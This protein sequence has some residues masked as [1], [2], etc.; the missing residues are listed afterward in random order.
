MSE[1][2]TQKEMVSV[3]ISRESYEFLKGLARKLE[4]QNNRAT[5]KP[6]FLVIR[7]EHWR[8]AHDDYH[9]GE[10][11]QVRVDWDGDPT[12]F[13]TKEEY[14]E[15]LR[16][17]FGKESDEAQPEA[18]DAAWERLDT[19]TE[20]L[21]HEEDNVFLTDGAYQEH[22]RL[23]GHNLRRNKHYSYM[24]HAGRNPEMSSLFQAIAEFGG[25]S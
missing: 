22:L 3:E 11:R 24:K 19:F 7:S 18:V 5:A 17:C 12:T 15:Y 9:S 14:T 8:V 13:R 2:A 25:A 23:N 16:C 1:A 20:E 4:T 10:T 21:Y 6:Y